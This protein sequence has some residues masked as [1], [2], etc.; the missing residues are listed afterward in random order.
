MSK[1]L[2]ILDDPSGRPALGA[3]GTI[4]QSSGDRVAVVEA[5]DPEALRKLRGIRSVTEGA[6]GAEVLADLDEGSRLF[7]QAWG[8]QGK[9]AT[10]Q[11]PGEGLDWDA[12]GFEAPD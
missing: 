7:A 1:W 8:E 9:M 12:E 4:L 5:P 10:K 2:V 6:P 3:A 11:R